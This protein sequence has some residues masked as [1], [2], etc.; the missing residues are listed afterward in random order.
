MPLDSEA[1]CWYRC[2]VFV[3][4]EE[5]MALPLTPSCVFLSPCWTTAWGGPYLVKLGGGAGNALKVRLC[6][7]AIRQTAAGPQ[8]PPSPL[9]CCV[10]LCH[11]SAYE[12][13]REGELLVGCLGS[14]S[15]WIRKMWT[16]SR[17]G[18]PQSC[19]TSLTESLN[20]ETRAFQKLMGLVANFPPWTRK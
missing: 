19:V 14:S 17:R 9:F 8:T 12:R 15:S 2:A 20:D 18:P 10:C 7:D 16:A 4:H 6:W 5:Q 1:V 11:F 13:Q 3:E